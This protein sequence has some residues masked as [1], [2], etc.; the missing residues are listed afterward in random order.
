M[1]VAMTP[2]YHVTCLFTLYVALCE[3]HHNLATLQTDRQIDVMPVAFR[4]RRAQIE[5]TI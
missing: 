5:L 4:V 1:Q 2:T 3:C